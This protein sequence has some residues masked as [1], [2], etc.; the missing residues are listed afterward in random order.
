VLDT[1]K[2]RIVVADDSRLARPDDGAAGASVRTC[3]SAC[4]PSESVA[5]SSRSVVRSMAAVVSLLGLQ[6]AIGYGHLGLAM[7]LQRVMDAGGTLRW[8]PSRRRNVVL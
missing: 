3:W 6:R 1:P 4:V 5:T 8:P 2:R 7:I